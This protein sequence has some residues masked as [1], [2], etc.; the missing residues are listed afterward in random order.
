MVIQYDDLPVLISIQDA[1]AAD[2]F[3]PNPM[4]ICSGNVEAMAQE[5]DFIV[6]GE[7]NI[8]G[9]EHFYLETN[10]ALVIP[11]E[12]DSLEVYSSTQNANETQVL[13]AHACGL[14]ASNVV[15]RV[16]RYATSTPS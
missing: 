11:S 8:G 6:E 16:K 5:S 2:S 14:P 4:V 10:C 13:C 9:Q 1:I 7:V 12:N 3:Y 15:C